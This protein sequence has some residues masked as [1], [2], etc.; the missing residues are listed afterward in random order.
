[1][2]M[3][4][5]C[6]DAASLQRLL[7]GTLSAQA[8]ADLS[9]HL[10]TCAPCR[11]ALDQLATAG[12]SFSGLARDLKQDPPPPEPGLQ[13]VLKEAAGS[14]VLGETQAEPRADA[15]EELAFLAPSTKPGHLG[16]L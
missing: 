3:T 5:S 8:Q 12:R 13:R 9:Q 6:P 10:D 16:R 11:A 1:M 2:P 14:A 4:P 15:Q 7:D